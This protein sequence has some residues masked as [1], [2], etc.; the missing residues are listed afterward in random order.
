VPPPL[1]LLESAELPASVDAERFVLGAIILDGEH[2]LETAAALSETDFSTPENRLIFRRMLDLHE[3]DEKIDRITL[4]NELTKRGEL[5][6]TVSVSYLCS[7][8]DGLPQI[9]NLDSYVRIVKE[10]STRRRLIA[11]SQSIITRAMVAT[12]D[13]RAIVSCAEESLL[14]INGD[15]GNRGAMLPG[16]IIQGFE[17]GI[18]AFLDTSRRIKGV[19]TGFVKFDEMT[20]GL[21]P[22]ELTIV[23]AR[24]AMGKTSLCLNIADYVASNPKTPRAAA[25]FSLEMSKESLIT[26]LV[27]TRARV[28]QSR[29]NAGFLT[30]DER[31]HLQEAT[32][33]IATI[34][35]LIDDTSGLALIDLHSRVRRLQASYDLAAVVLDYL[36][37]LQGPKRENRVQ[38]VSYLSR[39]LKLM[40][41]DLKLPFVVLS[42]LSRDC[43]KRAGDHRPILSDLR[44]S[45]SIEQDADVVAFIYREE[46]YRPDKE[47]VNGMAEMILAKQRNG[48]TGTVK[49]AFIRKYTKFENIATDIDI[50]MASQEYAA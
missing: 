44:E 18:N 30:N 25:V 20:G 26:R 50:S 13:V 23:A 32:S 12:D 14:D 36:Q 27:C 21:K 1:A 15:H 29:F 28:D 33:D 35:L 3:R 46:L 5:G 4:R 43:E 34:P 10:R 11:V 6:A 47:S 48:P 38:E 40:A 2:F 31:Y 19:S 49:L 39:G 22:G 7:L 9:Y 24:P 16:D 42:Q 17:G 8:D 45:G 37:L 41:K